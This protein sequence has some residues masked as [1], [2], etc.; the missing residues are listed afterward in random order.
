MR[1]VHVLHEN[2]KLVA[3]GLLGLL[4]W[5]SGCGG[6]EGES[7]VAPTTPPPGQSAKEI[8]DAMKK[9]YGPTGVPSNNSP[10]RRKR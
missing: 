7:K 8:S 6:S 3:V 9:A 4:A 10:F 2:R 1:I 5:T